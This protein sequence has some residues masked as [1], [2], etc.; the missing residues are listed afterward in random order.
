[1]SQIFLKALGVILLSGMISELLKY[2]GWRGAPAV[3]ALALVGV[4]SLFGDTLSSF[5]EQTARLSELGGIGRY[6]EGVLKIIA[7]GL[8][9]GIVGD[10]LSELCGAGLARITA[11]VARLEILAILLP[12]LTEIIEKGLSLLSSR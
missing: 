7:V 6:A 11:T 1:M 3:V 5:L 2:L 10:I 9:S 4:V 8:L 12:F